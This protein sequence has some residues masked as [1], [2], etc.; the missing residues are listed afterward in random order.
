MVVL[1]SDRL[2]VKIHAGVS[3]M[4]LLHT[5]PVL[6]F[7]CVFLYPVYTVFCVHLTHILSSSV[8]THCVLPLFALCMRMVI[9]QVCYV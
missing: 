3:M 1:S 7:L 6:H 8:R 5:L 2:S 4:S 9:N